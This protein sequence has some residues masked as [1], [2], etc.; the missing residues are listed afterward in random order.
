MAPAEGAETAPRPVA[1]TGPAERLAARLSE[2]ER[3]RSTALQQLPLVRVVQNAD[4]FLA[5]DLA[6][7]RAAMA[8]WRA[9]WGE[10]LGVG[11]GD[12]VR[13]HIPALAESKQAAVEGL[14][15]AIKGLE[16]GAQRRTEAETRIEKAT[17]GA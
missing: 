1:D 13:P 9:A 3:D 5:D 4:A 8:E 11:R 10:L 17:K 6:R 14:A 7:A 12:R 15:R 16:D 2:L